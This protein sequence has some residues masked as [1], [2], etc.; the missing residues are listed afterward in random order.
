MTGNETARTWFYITTTN[1]LLLVG[2][3]RGGSEACAKREKPSDTTNYSVR[4]TFRHPGVR[5]LCP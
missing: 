2:K 1:G 3:T 5:P 4:P